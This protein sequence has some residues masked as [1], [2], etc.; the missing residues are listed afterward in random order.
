MGAVRVHVDGL[1][2]YPYYT[3]RNTYG[4]TITTQTG[5]LLPGQRFPCLFG[6]EYSQDA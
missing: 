1:G 4:G 2:I 3:A 5:R 6:V